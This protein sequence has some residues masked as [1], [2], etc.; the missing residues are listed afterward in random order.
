[1]T[2]AQHR[3]SLVVTD[4][5]DHVFAEDEVELIGRKGEPATRVEV[6]D[7]WRLR[8]EIGIEPPRQEVPSAPEVEFADLM[9]GQVPLSH[10]SVNAQKEATRRN[11]VTRPRL[12]EAS[13]YGAERPD[14]G[15]G[16]H[17]SSDP[18]EHGTPDSIACLR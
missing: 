13:V 8:I 16:Y 2:L 17:V 7:V 3:R 12:G 9:F 1:M 5:L 4:V 10:R 15:S 14:D 6:N 18:H 11:Q